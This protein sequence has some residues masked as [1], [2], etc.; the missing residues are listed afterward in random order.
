[1]GM[2]K[3]QWK[4]KFVSK[5]ILWL[6]VL[7][8]VF[9]SIARIYTFAS[10][11]YGVADLLLVFLLFL[12]EGHSVIH[13]LGFII[14]TV[15]LRRKGINYHRKVELDKRKLPSVTVIIP[16][17]NEPLDVL[18]LTFISIAG[19]D[20]KNKKIV[21]LDGSDDKYVRENKQLAEKYDITYFKPDIETRSKAQTVNLYLP[22]ISTKYVSIFDA[23]QNPMPDFLLE[24][25][26]LAEYSGNIA[27]VQTPQLYSNLNASPIAYGATLQQ[28]VFYETVC[29]SKGSVD[30]MFCCGTNFL[31]RT[32]VLKEV[33]G[34]DETSVTED[35]A[36]SV[37]IHSLGYRSIYYN[38]ARVF[39]MAPQDLESYFKQQFR[40]AVGS[41]GV[42]RELFTMKIKGQL[43]ISASQLWEY[44][45]SATYYFTGWSFF[46]LMICPILFL[47]FGVPSYFA[48]PYLYLATFI[49]YYFM[50]MANFYAT[51]K[52]RNYRLE[53][54]FTGIIMASVSFPILMKASL[55][56]ILG[57]KTKFQITGKGKGNIMNFWSLWP[58]T[59]MIILAG[60]AIFYGI[61]RISE[62]PYAISI[63][64]AWCLYHIVLL[65][66][67]YRF[68]KEPKIIKK[69]LLNYI[70]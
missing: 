44:F 68:N 63:N 53:D 11:V 67:I 27:F 34:F 48:N 4:I 9:Y 60:I 57:I 14:S 20:Y 7:S 59:F 38:H 5:I 25:V 39:G 37:R 10:N 58:W 32:E 55:F 1:M 2:G 22:K 54:I 51:M 18:E 31:M 23:D 65:S 21:F 19:L 17:K 33:G 40:W 45:L 49:P 62:N 30:A 41:V 50:T 42:L 35:F 36:S 24:T 46:I 66:N 16:A 47:L 8:I 43:T 3:K 52:R 6:T 12:A 69:S 29:E 26:A 61:M 64:I 28:S 13:S 56:G 70:K 15:R